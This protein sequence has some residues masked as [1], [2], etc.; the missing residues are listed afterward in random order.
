[1]GTYLY[2]ATSSGGLRSCWPIGIDD[3]AGIDADQS[4]AEQLEQAA[5]SA[6]TDFDV[7]GNDQI[8][9]PLRALAAS[10]DAWRAVSPEDWSTG[11]Q[12]V[13]VDYVL[14]GGSLMFTTFTVPHD[15]KLDAAQVAQLVGRVLSGQG[16]CCL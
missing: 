13:L 10:S 6:I 9:S 5:T 8:Y 16:S 1:M 11:I 12:V 4:M 15:R 3:Y 2:S 7:N 14:P